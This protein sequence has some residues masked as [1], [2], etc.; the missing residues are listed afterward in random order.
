MHG[1]QR[2][3]P[4]VFQSSICS[5][6][7]LS[8]WHNRVQQRKLRPTRTFLW[9]CNSVKDHNQLKKLQNYRY[10]EHQSIWTCRISN[11]CCCFLQ[12]STVEKTKT[13]IRT[14]RKPHVNSFSLPPNKKQ[15][16]I[17]VFTELYFNPQIYFKICRF[18]CASFSA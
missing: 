17:T 11:F 16:Q 6:R 14:V 15:L 4:Q 3:Y 8:Y 18:I 10:L 5:K 9:M 13:N 12:A 7:S 2:L 1:K